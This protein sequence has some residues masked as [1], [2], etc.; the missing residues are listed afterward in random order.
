M[1]NYVGHTYRNMKDAVSYANGLIGREYKWVGTSAEDYNNMTVAQKEEFA[2]TVDNYKTDVTENTTAIKAVESAYALH[3]LSLTAGRLIPIDANKSK[4]N[5][6]LTPKAQGG[7]GFADRTEQE[8]SWATG[9]WAAYS[10]ALTFAN[11]VAG[12]E[13]ATAEMVNCALTKLIE[14]WKR[15]AEGANYTQLSGIVTSAKDF[16]KSFQTLLPSKRSFFPL[17]SF[18]S[19]VFVCYLMVGTIDDIP[20]IRCL[21]IGIRILELTIHDSIANTPFGRLSHFEQMLQITV[22]LTMEIDSCTC[23]RMWFNRL[24]HP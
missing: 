21:N 5:W 10:H 8:K 11:A 9:S 7:P 24:V 1:R 19:S 13:N 6:A 3:R 23:N 22:L 17:I 2:T 18:I 4:L 20:G 14:A 12:N 16:I 15:L